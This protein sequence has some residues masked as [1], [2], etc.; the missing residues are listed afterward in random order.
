MNSTKRTSF[1]VTDEVLTSLLK[2]FTSML[3]YCFQ[4]NLN[5]NNIQQ[6]SENYLVDN[7]YKF[8]SIKNL[9]SKL[10]RVDIT[11]YANR[12]DNQ[13][14][15]SFLKT[16]FSSL[17]NEINDSFYCNDLYT[18]ERHEPDPHSIENIFMG[19]VPSG[20]NNSSYLNAP[21]PYFLSTYKV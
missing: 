16:A 12:E 18:I 19:L 20:N 4:N 15:R 21:S 13:E 10:L 3:R 2:D 8:G 5:I 9:T 14:F 1:N 17:Y 11:L 6:L 7:A